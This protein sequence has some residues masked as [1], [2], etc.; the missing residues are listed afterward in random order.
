M[1]KIE[2]HSHKPE[3]NLA[4]EEALCGLGRDVFMLWRNK[5]SV[6]V[7][8]FGVIEDDVDTDF[9]ASHGIEIVRRKSGGGCVYHDL[10]NVNYTFI[11]KDSREFTLEHFSR[12]MIAV[13]ECFG[14][15]SQLEFHHN[16]I[17]A[18]GSKI[19]GAAQYRH[20]GVLL[21]H[22]TL[23]FDSDL[24]IIPKVLKNSG[25][26]AN[27]RPLLQNDMSISEFMRCIY[28]YVQ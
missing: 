8:R 25:K 14:V 16:D 4:F 3:E 1:L 5:P 7:G 23:L 21:H 12:K 24:D 2:L 22:G 6:I 17:L 20:N 28:D 9:A 10:G 13:L 18:N 11:T 27:I 26:V 19:S 15:K